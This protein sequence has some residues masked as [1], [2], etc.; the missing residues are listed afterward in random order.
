VLPSQG[1]ERHLRQV[2]EKGKVADEVPG[3]V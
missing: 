1:A 3:A 2:V